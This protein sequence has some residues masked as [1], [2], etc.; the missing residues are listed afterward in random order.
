[1]YDSPKPFIRNGYLAIDLP[2]PLTATHVAERWL[3]H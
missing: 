1:M 3:P 2:L